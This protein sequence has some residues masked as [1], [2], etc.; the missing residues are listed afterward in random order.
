MLNAIFGV[1][2]E[3]ILY[4]RYCLHSIRSAFI[5][6]VVGYLSFDINTFSFQSAIRKGGLQ[7]LVQA[8]VTGSVLGDLLLIPG[9]SMV[10]NLITTLSTHTKTYIESYA[11]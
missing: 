5:T 10:Q 2:I 11:I 1:S 4:S 7:E 9:L 6:M 8:G 3:I